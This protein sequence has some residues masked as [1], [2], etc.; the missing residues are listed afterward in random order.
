[1]IKNRDIGKKAKRELFW[2]A[3][4]DRWGCLAF[5]DRAH[6]YSDFQ[7]WSDNDNRLEL[8]SGKMTTKK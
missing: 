1:M 3:N 7:N 5:F 6:F 2:L 8:F 4:A